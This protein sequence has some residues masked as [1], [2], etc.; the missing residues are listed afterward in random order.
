MKTIIAGKNEAGQR[1]DK[2]LF[3]LLNKAPKSFV[4]K[5]LRKKNIT[6]N[7][8]KAEGSEMVQ[9]EDEIKLF[10]SDETV[11]K[12]SESYVSPL[13]GQRPEQKENMKPAAI[14]VVYEDSN[15]LVV[16]KP[17]GLLSQKAKETDISLVEYLISYLLDTNSITLKELETFKPGICNRLDRNTS[18]LVAAGKTL[19]GL[20]TLSELFRERTLSKYYLCL[21]KGA[22]KEK[23]KITGYLLKDERTN[24]VTILSKQKENADYIETEYI[25][26]K[27]NDDYTLLRVKLITGK[28]HQIRAHLSSMGYPIIGDSKYGDRAVNDKFKKQFKLSHQL[29]HS[30][31]MIFPEGLEGEL[32]NLSGMKLTAEPPGYFEDI[33]KACI[34]RKGR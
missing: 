27:G 15:V 20:K 22:V 13:V 2:L 18:G 9:P 31:E 8:K 25:P 4:Y 28:T 7:G 21:V 3:K 12:F 16:N 29:L 5:M 26:L 6:L 19:A 33:L 34:E 1:L 32:A 30:Y 24:Q 17:A 10:L 14:Q 23:K 11:E